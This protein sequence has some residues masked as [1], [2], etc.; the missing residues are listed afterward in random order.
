MAKKTAVSTTSRNRSST[1]GGRTTSIKRHGPPEGGCD[2][3]AVLDG[4]SHQGKTNSAKVLSAVQA[5]R[6][7]NRSCAGL[8][9]L[10][11]EHQLVRMNEE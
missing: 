8:P 3:G 2:S 6:S 1:T 11:K 7:E 5:E 4:P 9:E 10:G